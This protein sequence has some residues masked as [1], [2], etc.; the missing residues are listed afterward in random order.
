MPGPLVLVVQ[1]LLRSRPFRM[2]LLQAGPVAAHQAM[3]LANEGR[4]RRLAVLH[5]DSV[6]AGRVSRE[7]IEGDIHWV[8]W[9]GDDPVEAYPPVEVPL[10]LALADRDRTRP[11]SPEDLPARRLRRA[12][13]ERSRAAGRAV[14]RLRPQGRRGGGANG[15]S[16]P[17]RER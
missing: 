8:V 7:V 10:D 13:A 4:W 2:F 3:Q 15:R 5:A 17:P 11:R 12:G 16:T 6:V 1:R 9:R 14:G